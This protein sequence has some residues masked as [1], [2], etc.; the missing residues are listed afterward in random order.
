MCKVVPVDVY[1]EGDFRDLRFAEFA[2]T[3]IRDSV[4]EK[5]KRERVTHAEQPVWV[6][7]D[8]P[9][10]DRVQISFLAAVRRE[11]VVEWKF[12]PGSLKIDDSAMQLLWN[13]EVVVG[14]SV[15]GNR[16]DLVFGYSWEEFLHE[17]SVTTFHAQAQDK[18]QKNTIFG[19]K[20]KG[21]SK[22]KAFGKAKG[23]DI[24]PT[25]Y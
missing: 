4:V 9:L 18:L 22:G 8:R 14:T 12:P 20:G 13:G 24:D 6:N 25:D 11:M 10:P 23:W 7:V 17:G 21:A 16:I 2:F 5:M 19:W 3:A 1:A 15:V